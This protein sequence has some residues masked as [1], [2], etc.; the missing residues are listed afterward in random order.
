MRINRLRLYLPRHPIKDTEYAQELCEPAI[1]R[2]ATGHAA[3]IETLYSYSLYSE[4]KLFVASTFRG[5]YQPAL[6]LIASDDA[7][8]GR[9]VCRSS[10]GK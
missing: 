7:N 2:F 4:Q 6:K 5:V 3:R 10:I 8:V 1:H 9:H